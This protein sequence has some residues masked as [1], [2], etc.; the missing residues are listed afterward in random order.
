MIVAAHQPLY[1]PWLGFF[2]KMAKA[3]LFVLMDDLQYEPQNFQNRNRVRLADGPA[4]VVVPIERGPQSDRVIDKRIDNSAVGREHW[5][6]RTWRTLEVN[7]SRSHYWNRY[8]YALHAVYHSPWE[9]LADLNLAL[10]DLAR[11]WLRIETPML[12]SSQLGLVGTKTDRIIDLCKRVDARAYLAGNGG[13]R[14]Y[15]D[16]EKLGRAGLGLIWQVFEHPVYPQRYAERGFDS[17]LAFLD[18]VLNCGPAAREV[19]FARS[20]PTR[21]VA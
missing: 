12:R 17:H 13:S 8:A 18:L 4:W 20:H 5:Q 1:L 15:L 10:I 11:D 21:L 14:R 19:L 7:Y 2:D 3:D 6:W 16:D 9:R